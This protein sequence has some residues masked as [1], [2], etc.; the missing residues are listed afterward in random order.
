MG[1]VILS[2]PAMYALRMH[3]GET[4]WILAGRPQVLALLQGGWKA[5]HLISTEGRDWVP[6]FQGQRPPSGPL[7]DLLA[8]CRQGVLFTSHDPAP[9]LRGLAQAGLEEILVLPSFP[10]E[11]RRV[12][13]HLRQRRVLESRG[14]RWWERECYLYPSLPEILQARQL[15]NEHHLNPDQQGLWAVHP[16]SGSLKKNWPWERFLYTAQL[17]RE[18]G[19]LQPIILFGPVEEE[20]VSVPI[21]PFQE[22]GFPT[23]KSPPLP[24]LAALFTLCRGYLGNDSGI[25]HLA[26]AV[27]IPTL[28]LFGPTDP[29]LWGPQGPRAAI[30][31]APYPCAPCSREERWVC[32]HQNC[33]KVLSVSQVFK[34]LSALKEKGHGGVATN[35]S[36]AF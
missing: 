1:D 8:S 24:V 20:G 28:A 35:P 22:A 17:I 3:Y 30:L 9:F 33:L 14:I 23:F 16:G 6:I 13:L 12:P 21:P 18:Q 19:G 26:A 11:E 25:T 29:L 34:A 32:P 36:D 27:G 4:P 10:D 2:L 15:L 7:A 31:S 5:L